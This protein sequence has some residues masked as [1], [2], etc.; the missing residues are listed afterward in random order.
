MNALFAAEAKYFLI[1]N[2]GT[3]GDFDP[4]LRPA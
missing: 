4:G 1:N 3:D 2:P